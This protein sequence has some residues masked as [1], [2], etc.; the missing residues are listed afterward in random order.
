MN[1]S[2]LFI[3]FSKKSEKLFGSIT[4]KV[5]RTCN[6]CFLYILFCSFKEELKIDFDAFNIKASSFLFIIFSHS[7]FNL[8]KIEELIFSISEPYLNIELINCLFTVSFKYIK[9]VKEGISC[10]KNIL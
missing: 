7:V 9:G 10:G 1:L 2:R 6:N 3:I 5:P 8:F 4:N